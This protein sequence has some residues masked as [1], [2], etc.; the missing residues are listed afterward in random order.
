MCIRDSLGTTKDRLGRAGWAF[1]MDHDH[2]GLPVRTT[3]IISPQSG[4]IMAEEE[5]LT[6]S[7]GRLNVAIPAVISYTC[8]R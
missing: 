6:T 3:L 1:A 7:A 2:G 8:F 5:M 4:R